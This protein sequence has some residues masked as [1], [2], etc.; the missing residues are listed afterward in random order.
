MRRKI[1]IG[2]LAIMFGEIAGNSWQIDPTPH[3]VQFMTVDNNVKLK[4]SIGAV[5]GGPWSC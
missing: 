3:T 5:P 4:C 2:V 1:L